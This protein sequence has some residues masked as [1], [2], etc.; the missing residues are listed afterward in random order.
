MSYCT[1]ENI[2]SEF[3]NIVFSATTTVTIDEVE[4]FIVESDSLID[5]YLGSKYV[6]PITGTKSLIVMRLLSIKLTVQ[7]IK[8]VLYYKF[9]PNQ[10][11]SKEERYSY[12]EKDFAMKLLNQIV[13]GEVTLSDA[14]ANS[15][16]LVSSCN[17][18]SAREFTFEYGVDQW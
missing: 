16:N 1:K 7:R 17:V 3:R 12:A 4:R 15:D 5:M 11:Q 13:K 2:Q 9:S 10:E 8:D 14:T 6:T 18:D